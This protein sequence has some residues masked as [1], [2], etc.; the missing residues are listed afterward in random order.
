MRAALAL[1][2]LAFALPACAD[3]VTL[4]CVRDDTLYESAT[5]AVSNALGQTMFVGRNAQATN[6]RRRALVRFDVAAAI[7]AGS[8][9]TSATLSLNMSQ[10]GSPGAQPIELHRALADWGEATSNGGAAS[11]AGVAATPGDATWLHR[12]FNGTFWTAAGGDFAAGA[13]ASTPVS[14]EGPYTWTGMTADVQSWLE[15]PAA[16]FGWLL[17]GNETV[18]QSVKRFD[19]REHVNPLARPA[20]TIEYAQPGTPTLGTSWGRIRASYR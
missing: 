20:L 15:A 12:F 13:S 4:P 1:F 18:S 14:V 2:L 3:T 16:N 9:I 7:P 10:A 8:T 6:F 17:L 11:G 19:T 5:G